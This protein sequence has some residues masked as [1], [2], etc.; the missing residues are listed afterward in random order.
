MNIINII[1]KNY[2]SIVESICE[3]R[4]RYMLSPYLFELCLYV[5]DSNEISLKS[6]K[7]SN[8]NDIFKHD[9]YVI[10]KSGNYN[11]TLWDFIGDVY[12]LLS[13]YD[14]E[15]IIDEIQ[16]TNITKD[17][18][19]KHIETKY[20]DLI[21]KWLDDAYDNYHDREIEIAEEIIEEFLSSVEDMEA[22]N[23]DYEE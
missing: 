23:E 10:C 15:C 2:D 7:G 18:V 11:S 21:E 6:E 3:H 13:Y 19:E 1:N 5:D 4:K 17:I 12:N 9:H 14:L 16:D 8:S 20:P 22:E